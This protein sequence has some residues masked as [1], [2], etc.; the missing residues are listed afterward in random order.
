V[1]TCGCRGGVSKEFVALI[2]TGGIL[3]CHFGLLIFFPFSMGPGCKN[4]SQCCRSGM[5]PSMTVQ[6][7]KPF[8]LFL[9]LVRAQKQRRI[10]SEGH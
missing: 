1:T 3:S 5:E 2:I 7:R 10:C 9:P 6:K 8:A 4:D